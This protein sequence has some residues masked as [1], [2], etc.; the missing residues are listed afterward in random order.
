MEVKLKAAAMD[1]YER[2]GFTESKS[3]S[4]IKPA[5]GRQKCLAFKISS[6]AE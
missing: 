6:S 5:R 1:S 3:S 4:L 2:L